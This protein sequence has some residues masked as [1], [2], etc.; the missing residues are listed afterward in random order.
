MNQSKPNLCKKGLKSHTSFEALY[1][2]DKGGA[3]W[4]GI[5]S[6]EHKLL[7]AMTWLHT[8]QE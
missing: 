8:F 1:K 3:C 2:F 7:G 5:C 4:D 6:W